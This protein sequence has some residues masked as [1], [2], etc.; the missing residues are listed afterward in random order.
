MDFS[1]IAS[2]HM[3]VPLEV[4]AASFLLALALTPLTT[5]LDLSVSNA[6]SDTSRRVC[7]RISDFPARIGRVVGS[8]DREQPAFVHEKVRNSRMSLG[9]SQAVPK[10]L[11]FLLETG[12]MAGM[13]DCAIGGAIR[14]E[15]GCRGRGC[16]CSACIAP[17]ADGAGGVPAASGRAAYRGGC[18]SSRLHG[19]SASGRVD[20]PA[21]FTGALAARRGDQDRTQGQCTGQ[22]PSPSRE[23]RGRDASHRIGQP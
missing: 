13:P 9:Q 6:G 23:I 20:P 11:Q 1:R 18:V 15:P 7:F 19:A 4:V 17:R 8:Y 14:G 16:V 3:H 12:S 10:P 21:G 22:T 5:F 2:E